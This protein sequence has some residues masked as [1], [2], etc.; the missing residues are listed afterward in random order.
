MVEEVSVLV[1]AAAHREFGL[2][3]PATVLGK[4]GRGC[5]AGK[6]WEERLDMPDSAE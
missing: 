4:A 5:K 6:G 2:G 3:G 1:A